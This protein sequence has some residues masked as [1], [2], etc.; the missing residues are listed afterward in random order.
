M[1]TI[2]LPNLLPSDKFRNQFNTFVQVLAR[3]T[4]F[5]TARCDVQV[6]NIPTM[7]VDIKLARA[8]LAPHTIM[9][10][11]GFLQAAIVIEQVS[12]P[13]PVPPGLILCLACHTLLVSMMC[14]LIFDKLLTPSLLMP[15]LSL[16]F[17]RLEVMMTPS[18]FD[19][20]Q[21]AQGMCCMRRQGHKP[22]LV[23]SG[24]I[25]PVSHF[26]MQNKLIAHRTLSA[27]V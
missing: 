4:L 6:Y 26:C 19:L 10:G 7:H 20:R 1:S 13:N 23:W 22:L 16:L 18:T 5:F 15:P 27:Y 3:C 14:V 11:P 8:N 2:L 24:S 12:C 9:R 25:G 21:H 17:V